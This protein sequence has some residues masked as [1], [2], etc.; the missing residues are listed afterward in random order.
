M[1]KKKVLYE[2]VLLD[3]EK[4]IFDRHC[5]RGLHLTM[6]SSPTDLTFC[7][8]YL[9]SPEAELL[10]DQLEQLGVTEW[11]EVDNFIDP[12]EKLVSPEMSLSRN[13]RIKLKADTEVAFSG[14]SA[15]L[16]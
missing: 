8:T 12:T 7:S 14:Q 10:A 3:K 11:Q 2:L 16:P 15:K 13:A 4:F 6:C 1:I 9:L 5:V